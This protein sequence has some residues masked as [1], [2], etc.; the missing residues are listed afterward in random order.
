MCF[1]AK[2]SWAGGI[3]TLANIEGHGHVRQV[4]RYSPCLLQELRQGVRYQQEVATIRL[5]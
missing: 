3:H 1:G 2:V 4:L 5:Y